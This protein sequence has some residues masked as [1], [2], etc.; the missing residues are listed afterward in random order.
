MGIM[1]DIRTG[2]KTMFANQMPIPK[3]SAA[4][5]AQLSALDVPAPGVKKAE[6]ILPAIVSP[7]PAPVVVPVVIQQPV[8]ATHTKELCPHCNQP[9][10]IKPAPVVSDPND[11]NMRP[12]D[13]TE[14]QRTDLPMRTPARI[15]YLLKFETME[16][17][18]A[19]IENDARRYR[20]QRALEGLL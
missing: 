14:E 2:L 17:T 13:W 9:M 1:S 15:Q 18:R 16:Q 4:F 7:T 5:S 10:P 19:R 20:H 8:A 11:L 12:I 3:A 6:I